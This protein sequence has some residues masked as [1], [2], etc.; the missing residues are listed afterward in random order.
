MKIIIIGA[1]KVGYNL[2]E[3]LSKSNHNV[4]II[5]R[6]YAAL[7][8]AE[9]NLEVLCIKGS[10]VSTGILME[11]GVDTTDLLI[12]VTGSDE[13]NMVCCL[14][15]KKLGVKST[16]ARIRD[17]EYA[18]ELLLL[19]EELGLDIEVTDHFCDTFLIAFSSVF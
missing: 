1:G 4:I 19:K 6:N 10:G 5:D 7:S 14:T 15:A 8:K 13:V 18:H 2:A 9:E 17:Y 3:N 12:A 16:V 11:A